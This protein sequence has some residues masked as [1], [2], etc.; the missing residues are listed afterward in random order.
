MIDQ[1]IEISRNNQRRNLAVRVSRVAEE[2]IKQRHPWIFENSITSV[3][4]AGDS[5]D[6]AVIFDQ[7]RKFLALGLWDPSSPIRIRLM[8]Y[9]NPAEINKDWF[10]NRLSG[11]IEKRNGIDLKKTNGF[12]LVHGENDNF[13]GLV[14]DRYDRILVIKLYTIA[15]IPHFKLL[16]E[17]LQ[18]TFPYR[19]V[20]LRLSRNV[21]QEVNSRFGLFDGMIIDGDKIDDFILFREN[22]LLFEAQPKVGHKTGFYL[23]QR[24][25]RSKVGEMAVDRNVLNVFSYNGGFSVYAAAGGAKSIT[26]V[27]LN[28]FALES[29]NRNFHHNFGE[30][31]VQSQRHM[32]VE[33]DAFEYLQNAASHKKRYDMVILD[34]P[35]FAQNAKQIP[36]ALKSYR[37][38]TRLALKLINPG[39][40]LVQASCSSRISSEQFFEAIQQEITRSGRNMQDILKTSHAVDH[41][42]SFPEGE[43]LKC[44]FAEIL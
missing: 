4:H 30:G 2:K 31:G 22:N 44:F 29:A 39:G 16:I 8:Q 13:P 32:I 26:S 18:E 21:E 41:P 15:W 20:V 40:I 19:S 17:C 11:A 23:D 38:L 3:S 36:Q 28:H 7:N 34:P 6:F 42:I 37:K 25:N 27:D 24:D 35:M 33:E 5:G 9:F 43:Y 12:R 10:S 14:V 1:L